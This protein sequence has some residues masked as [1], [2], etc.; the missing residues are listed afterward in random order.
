MRTEWQQP[1]LLLSELILL[2][3]NGQTQE[4]GMGQGPELEARAT[5]CCSSLK[6]CM[7]L[8]VEEHARALQCGQNWQPELR[9]TQSLTFL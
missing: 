9:F 8:G 7:H 4:G 1:P 2:L 5:F 3:L 6:R